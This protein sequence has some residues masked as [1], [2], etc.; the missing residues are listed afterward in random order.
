MNRFLNNKGFSFIGILVSA[1]IVIG[2]VI[3]FAYGYFN[4][5]QQPDTMTDMSNSTKHTVYGQSMDA[6]KAISCQ[7]NLQ[8]IRSGI[9]M[10]IQGDE[11]PPATLQELRFPDEMYSCPMTKQPY[12]YNPQNGVVQCPSHPNF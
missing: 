1:V 8:Q 7:S 4:K 6:A 3:F 2:A 11:R 5:A 10:A 12:V 9:N